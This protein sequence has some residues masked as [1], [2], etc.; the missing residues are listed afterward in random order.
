VIRAATLD[1]VPALV[2][3][4]HEVQAIH[5]A[6]MPEKYTDPPR[7]EI[8]LQVREAFAVPALVILVAESAGEVVGYA[9]VK[10][11]DAAGHTYARPRLTAHVDQLGVA[12]RARRD[13]HGRALMAAVEAQARTWGAAAVTLDVQTFNAEAVA[14]YAALGYETPTVRMSKRL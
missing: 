8:E 4:N 13:G 12:A 3:L 11:V 7:D 9:M 14:F 1:D 10:R 5:L 6:A 2:E